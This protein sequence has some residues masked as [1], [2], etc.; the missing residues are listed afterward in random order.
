MALTKIQSL[1]ITDGTIVNADINASAAI[2]STKLSGVANTPAFAL[3]KAATQATVANADTLITWSNAD[4]DTDSGFSNANDSY[5]IPT[6]KGGKYYLSVYAGFDYGTRFILSIFKNA[7]V[8]MAVDGEEGNNYAQI[9]MTG[10]VSL[11]AGDVLK[12][13]YYSV[14]STGT[15]R[16]QNNPG[17]YV[18]RFEGFKLAE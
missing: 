1:G 8:L 4:I 11:N 14:S 13:Y 15:L 2:V 6:G 12:V 10:I 18:T 7:G 9:G 5:T 16:F 17:E 3:R